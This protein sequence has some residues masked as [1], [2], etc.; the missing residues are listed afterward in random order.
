MAVAVV[1]AGVV[2]AVAA[3]EEA[4]VGAEGD[5]VAVGEEEV[6]E[7][8]GDGVTSGFILGTGTTRTTVV[9]AAPHLPPRSAVDTALPKS[10]AQ[11]LPVQLAQA[12]IVTIRATVTVCRE[13]SAPRLLYLRWRVYHK[14][15][16]NRW[17][18]ALTALRFEPG[19][20]A[21][22]STT[23]ARQGRE[24]PPRPWGAQTS[25]SSQS[26]GKRQAPR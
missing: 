17:K 12:S 2:V 4:V 1:G 19:T 7:V 26:F 20:G 21:K 25:H 10:E 22:V 9:A 14:N 18:T 3:A 15:H 24:R 8:E 6:V 5:G 16:V 13:I 11:C 23:S